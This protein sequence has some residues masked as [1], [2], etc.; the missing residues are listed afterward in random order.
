VFGAFVFVD[1]SVVFIYFFKKK[2][3]KKRFLGGLVPVQV[4]CCSWLFR[5]SSSHSKKEE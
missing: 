2:K 4:F 5:G 3:K 1:L